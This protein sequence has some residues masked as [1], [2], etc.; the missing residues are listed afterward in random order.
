[1][2][3]LAWFGATQPACAMGDPT[4]LPS[5]ARRLAMGEISLVLGVNGVQPC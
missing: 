5:T 2:W 1:M 3:A 4:Q